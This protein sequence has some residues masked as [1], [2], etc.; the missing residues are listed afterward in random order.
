MNKTNLPLLLF[1]SVILLAPSVFAQNS[2]RQHL[3]TKYE[4]F[5]EPDRENI[6]LHLNKTIFSQ[7][8]HIWFS[9]Y[10]F[11]QNS[12]TPSLQTTNLYVCLY[13]KEGNEVKRNLLYIEGGVGHG[14]F[15]I[16]SSLTSGIYYIRAYTNWMKNFKHKDSFIQKIE[17]FPQ[18]PEIALPDITDQFDVQLLPESGYILE[19]TNNT[20]GFKIIGTDG[21]GKKI[22]S[23]T[24]INSDGL[25]ILENIYNNHLGFGKFGY[26]QDGRRQYKL[27]ISLENGKMIESMLPRPQSEGILIKANNLDPKR[28]LLSVSTNE[29]TLNSNKGALFF[30]AFHKNA[31]LV[32]EEFVLNEKELVFSFDKAKLPFGVNTLTLFDNK[33]NVISSRLFFNEFAID[34]PE[35]VIGVKGES[36][37]DSVNLAVVINKT[38]MVPFLLSA[39]TLPEGTMANNPF[40]S[41]FSSF[42]L[43]PYL[44]NPIEDP[45]YYFN[46]FNRVKLYELDLMLLVQGWG[47]Y[48]W[49]TIFKDTPANKFEFEQGITIKGRALNANLDKEK[50]LWVNDGSP[51]GFYSLDLTK[52]KEFTKSGLVFYNNDS[53]R[54]ALTDRKGKLRAPDLELSFIPH[55]ESEN[56]DFFE[57]SDYSSNLKSK[58][59]ET[60][61]APLKLM[62][63]TVQLDEVTVVE[64]RLPR[65][66][67]FSV[68]ALSTV[69]LVTNEEIN[70]YGSLVG[71]L[72]KLGFLAII[73]TDA[74]GF[75]KLAVKASGRKL[76]GFRN[77][78]LSLNGFPTDGS[79]L[80]GKPLSAFQAI[81]YD[82]IKQGYIAFTSSG[83]Y[84]DL[85]APKRY[86]KRL[87]S[88]G[89]TKPQ[90]YYEPKY[91]YYDSTVFEHYGAVNWQA[92]LLSDSK[93]EVIFS[94][95]KQKQQKV[96]VFIEGMGADGKLLSTVK[97]VQLK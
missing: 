45:F 23:A 47:S 86:I 13:D 89:F 64:R 5:F 18:T 34:I 9:A 80:V 15:K 26:F 3:A 97:T 88:D 44:R 75:T 24:L 79:D 30:V 81:A 55:V 76:G 12:Q 83:A 7:E 58:L 61:D 54:L 40:N 62:G 10:V 17:V 4:A 69:K 49:E 21:T 28:L 91:A 94:F 70:R 27:R 32:V 22:I 2:L 71:Y 95:P 39:S 65:R 8:E 6:H 59:T 77:I 51:T 60:V 25:P 19:N 66:S 48:D 14:D 67:R 92:L 53:L 93:N 56:L 36:T 46:E 82:D 29:R 73:E 31:S 37:Q 68:D 50:S 72:R 52:N 63:N 84:V 74:F 20:V 41:I 38:D 78:P 33:F 96:K 35:V 42:W 11:D 87:I 57:S 85:N 16:D 90:K 43:T 1:V